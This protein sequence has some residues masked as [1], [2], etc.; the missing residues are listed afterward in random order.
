MQEVRFI[1][2]KNKW[3]LERIIIMQEM[4]TLA[5]FSFVRLFALTSI[6][7]IVKLMEFVSNCQQKNMT[8]AFQCVETKYSEK[9]RRYRQVGSHSSNDFSSNPS[10][11]FAIRRTATSTYRLYK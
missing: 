2:M 5:F 7:S 8:P 10:P 11:S 9:K 3:K 1:E 4:A 6:F